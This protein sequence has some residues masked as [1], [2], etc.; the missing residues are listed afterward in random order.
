MNQEK[1]KVIRVLKPVQKTKKN[2]P[3]YYGVAGAAIGI[4]LTS[5]LLFSVLGKNSNGITENQNTA[6]IVDNENQTDQK[7]LSKID[8][9]TAN[10]ENSIE[11]SD[12]IEEDSAH[13][14]FNIPQPK[15]NEINGIFT[16]KKTE[17]PKANPQPTS[18][19]NPFGALT[20]Q[21][22]K[23]HLANVKPTTTVKAAVTPPK[24]VT[25]SMLK[26]QASQSVNAA[27]TKIN[28]EVKKIDLNKSSASTTKPQP[29]EKE[30]DVE[31]PKATVQISVTT[32][33]KE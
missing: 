25:T 30:P 1:Q 12:N 9:V 7:N 13:E 19:D 31:T 11:D 8:A 16:H 4:A 2:A 3:I 21:E 32:S 28:N 29:K 33:V 26:A 17:Q 5:V 6:Q 14:G 23:P 18:A 10:R 22:S 27:A 20:G 24:P 15:A